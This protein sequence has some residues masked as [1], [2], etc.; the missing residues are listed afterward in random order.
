MNIYLP[1]VAGKILTVSKAWILK[2]S[3]FVSEYEYLCTI[4]IKS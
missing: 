1:S 4:I 3:H 2:I